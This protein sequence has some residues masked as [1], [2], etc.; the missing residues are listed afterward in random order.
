MKLIKNI[1]IGY[2]RSIYKCELRDLSDLNIIFGRNDSGKS[3]LL[4]ALNL[5]FNGYT[6]PERV[7]KFPIDF[8]RARSNEVQRTPNARKFIYVK[9]TFRTPSNYRASLGPEFFVK[10]TW[11]TLNQEGVE[12]HSST[13]S[14]NNVGYLSRFLKQVHFHYIPAIK[15]R[16]IFQYLLGQVHKTL[17]ADEAF[18]ASLNDFSANVQERTQALAQSIEQNLSLRSVLAPPQNVDELF[19]SLDFDTKSPASPES[20]S[21]T[22]QRGDGIQV[23][24]IPEILRFI[25]DNGSRY[26][27]W[28]FE[29]PENSLELAN[30][31]EEAKAL[32]GHASTNH[33][34]CFTTSHSP[35]FFNMHDTRVK[36]YFVS[37]NEMND[38]WASKVQDITNESDHDCMTLMGDSVYLPVISASLSAAVTRA[39]ELQTARQ[40]LEQAITALQKPIVFVEG[41]SDVRVFTAAAKLLQ[42]ALVHRVRFVEGRGTIA[43]KPLAQRGETLSNITAT[44]PVFV[45]TDD[46][47]AARD[48][49]SEGWSRLPPAGTWVRHPNGSHWLRIPITNEASTIL[50]RLGLNLD[51]AFTLELMF[52]AALRRRALEHGSYTIEQKPSFSYRE[53]RD[54]WSLTRRYPPTP[55]ND[56]AFYLYPLDGAS[57]EGFS[58]WVTS[59]LIL[60]R[61]NYAQFIGILDGLNAL[62]PL[63]P[64]APLP[65]IP[66][67]NAAPAE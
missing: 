36:R 60:N 41:A 26:H 32:L 4:R 62:L 44:R 46:D 6:N 43:L 7:F 51:P 66:V 25:C 39:N 58:S 37:K 14:A 2:F 17:S 21:L 23:R 48:L 12:E 63:E 3:N 1:E 52:S 16:K 8:A 57:K 38:A 55:E 9:V 40:T 65:V 59:R 42:P 53:H 31:V 35:A 61:E 34:Q 28:G 22:L 18:Q 13:I 47:K 54:I 27:I 15:D 19:Q 20:Y 29:E 11:S 64:A 30:A 50:T 10:K 67:E 33:I 56:E 49:W 5:F 24:H 45:I